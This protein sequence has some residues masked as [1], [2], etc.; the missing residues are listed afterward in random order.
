MRLTNSPR[1]IARSM[2]ISTTDEPNDMPT[3]STLRNFSG[4]IG[5]PP[6][7]QHQ[8]LLE[9]KADHAD[10]ANGDDDVLD[11]EVVPFVPDPE[12]DADAAG[13]HLGGDDHQPRHA[14]REAHAG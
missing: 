7:Q 8:P 11:L 5:E 1:L 2:P 4:C 12:T 13:E 6:R 10:G 14:D 9:Q 3:L